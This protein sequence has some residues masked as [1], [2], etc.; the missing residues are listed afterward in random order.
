MTVT[1]NWGPKKHKKWSQNTETSSL[2]LRNISFTVAKQWFRRKHLFSQKTKRICLVRFFDEAGYPETPYFTSFVLDF[3]NQQMHFWGP[4]WL[5]LGPS[6]AQNPVFYKVFE[7]F[8]RFA[9]ELQKWRKQLWRQSRWVKMAP[10]SP[11]MVPDS[12]DH[13][14][15]VAHTLKRFVNPKPPR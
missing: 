11:V 15:P 4:F 2:T 8:T 13:T 3:R 14:H 10:E 12:T 9:F 6:R 1:L 5:H 7:D